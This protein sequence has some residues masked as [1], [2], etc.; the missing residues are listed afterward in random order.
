MLDDD[1]IDDDSLFDC[2]F[3]TVAENDMVINDKEFFILSLN[4][5]YL[6]IRSD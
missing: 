2:N 3:T 1:P 5:L 4:K 6:T